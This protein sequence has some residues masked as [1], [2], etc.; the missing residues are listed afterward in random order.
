MSP[1][2]I[3]GE[4]R[5]CSGQ[6]VCLFVEIMMM[7][8]IFLYKDYKAVT[9]D[10]LRLSVIGNGGTGFEFGNSNR[11]LHRANTNTIY[12]ERIQGTA[13]ED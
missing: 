2:I 12:E 10:T 13:R 1:P 6:L 7:H 5:A 4:S 9:T 8:C 3:S 11:K